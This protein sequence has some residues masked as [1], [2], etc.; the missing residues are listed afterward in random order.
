MSRQLALSLRLPSDA[1]FDNFLPGD[2]QEALSAVRAAANGR[3]ERFVTLWGGEGCGKSHLLQAACRLADE[4]RRPAFYL[5]LANTPRPEPELLSGM[6]KMGLIAI[7]DIDAIAGQADW[8]EALYQLY[9]GIR[10]HLGF[11]LV[12]CRTPLTQ[13]PLKLPDLKSR[14]SWGPIYRLMPLEDGEK[15]AVIRN[16]AQQKGLAL[17][18]ET[19]HFLITRHSRNLSNLLKLLDRLD[20]ASL[21]AKRKLTLPFVRRYLDNQDS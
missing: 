16:A 19:L 18:E 5:S 12:T 15:A 21:E 3:G 4:K 13:L 2:N 1:G 7:D 8:E 9:N 14:L 20:Q 17:P 10:E 6:E 11:L